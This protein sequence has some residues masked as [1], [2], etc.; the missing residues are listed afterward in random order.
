MAGRST[1]FLEVTLSSAGMKNTRASHIQ[2]DFTWV[3]GGKSHI[4]LGVIAQIL[5]PKVCFMH[6]VD[7][8]IT[9]Y[10]AETKDLSGQFGWFLALGNQGV[11]PCVS[12]AQIMHFGFRNLANRATQ[13]YYYSPS[14]CAATRNYRSR[15]S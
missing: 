3:L 2:H 7:P 15:S 11:R 12:P 10:F 8:S 6:S 14:E 1:P 4:C 9:E 13:L 5:S